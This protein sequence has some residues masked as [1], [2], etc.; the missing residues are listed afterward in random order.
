M[1]VVMTEAD[2][3]IDPSTHVGPIELAFVAVSATSGRVAR[4]GVPFKGSS[5]DAPGGAGGGGSGGG[6]GDTNA[7]GGDGEGGNDADDVLRDW[8]IMQTRLDRE[9]EAEE[10]AKLWRENQS[11]WL[12]RS[13]K[14]WHAR[15]RSHVYA[16]QKAMGIDPNGSGRGGGQRSGGS[17]IATTRKSR[18]AGEPLVQLGSGGGK[19]GK[20]SCSL[21]DL[22]RVGLIKPGEERLFIVYQENTWKATLTEDGHIVFRGQTF[23]SPSAWAIFTKRLTNPTKKADDGWKS[24]RYGEPDGPTL[25][26]IK[27]EYARLEQLRTAG[28]NVDVEEAG[29]RLSVGGGSPSPRSTPRKRKSSDT[30]VASSDDMSWTVK[31]PGCEFGTPDPYPGVSADENMDFSVLVGKYVCV[32][33]SGQNTWWAGKVIK[34]KDFDTHVEADILYC[35]GK[36]ERG[37]DIEELASGGELVV[38]DE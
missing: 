5:E 10:L 13:K 37:I 15:H 29:K 20:V 16:R 3:A 36:I 31:Y 18:P 34:L 7:P 9:E 26:M 14:T 32:Y 33:A 19:P 35:T 25:D 22:I 4:V 12:E 24:A 17:K 30:V 21:Q 6:S 2:D 23:T 1:A 27:G 8:Q 28:M 11:E 38:L